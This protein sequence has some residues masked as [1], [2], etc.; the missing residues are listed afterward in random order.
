M[1]ARKATVV[2]QP[3]VIRR[4]VQAL[5]PRL[6]GGPRATPRPAVDNLVKANPGLDAG[7][8]LASVKASLP[9]FF[10]SDPNNPGAGRAPASGT[11]TG[12]G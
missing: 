8:Q 2:N 1:V 12:A 9:A 6:R 10:P 5:A 4:F 11:R 3:D 7:F